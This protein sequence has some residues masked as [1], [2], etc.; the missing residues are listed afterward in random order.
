MKKHFQQSHNRQKTVQPLL[1]LFKKRVQYLQWSS[2]RTSNDGKCSSQNLLIK[3]CYSK[4]Y[5][6]KTGMHVGLIF[7][8]VFIKFD[9]SLGFKLREFQWT[10]PSFVF[11]TA[12]S[13]NVVD[14]IKFCDFR[15]V[16]YFKLRDKIKNNILHEQTICFSLSKQTTTLDFLCPSE[17]VKF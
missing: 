8:L 16:H 17:R 7:F 5:V 6:H 3:S 13:S 14:F 12:F 15:T 4:H 9:S 2:I 11:L 10:M 1:N